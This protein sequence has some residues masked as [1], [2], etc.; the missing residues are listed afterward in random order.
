ADRLPRQLSGGQQQ[1]VALARAT[2]YQPSLVLMDE[3]LGALDRRLRE[4]LQME[5]KRVHKALGMTVLYVTHD[6]EEAMTMSD[7]VCLLNAGRIEQIGTPE[8]LY[9]RPETA[10]VANFLGE[11]NIL[12]GEIVSTDAT[13]AS[14]RLHSG[15]LVR[16]PNSQGTLRT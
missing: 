13:F 8:Q 11:S 14:V 2:V 5:I 6:Q 15:E 10:Y 1:R 3:P 7:R 4:Q 16:V 12:D 9:F